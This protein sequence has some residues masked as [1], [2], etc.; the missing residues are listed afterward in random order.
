MDPTGMSNDSPRVVPFFFG[1]LM[2][3]VFTLKKYL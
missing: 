1:A 3:V 2:N